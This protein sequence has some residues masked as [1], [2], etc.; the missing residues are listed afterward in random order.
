MIDRC[1]LATQVSLSPDRLQIGADTYDPETVPHMEVVAT[2]LVRP[3]EAMGFGDVKFMAAIGAFLGWPA[4]VFSLLASS[5]IGSSVALTLI[6]LGKR[7]RSSQIPY[8]PHIAMAALI[9]VFGGK[10]FVKSWFGLD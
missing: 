8:G 1:Y 3:R 6:L 4:T 5:V 9:W 10:E 2:S 7:N